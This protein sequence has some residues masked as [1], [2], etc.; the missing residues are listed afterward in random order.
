VA[1]V[2]PLS[3]WAFTINN[4]FTESL[5][6]Q[7]TAIPILRTRDNRAASWGARL[8]MM[9]SW[10]RFSGSAACSNLVSSALLLVNSI[11]P[12][13]AAAA[14]ACPRLCCHRRSNG[15][16]WFC[17]QRREVE[18]LRSVLDFEGRGEKH[19]ESMDLETCPG[20][21][22]VPRDRISR[23]C[24]GLRNSNNMGRILFEAKLFSPI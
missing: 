11:D 9:V 4:L 7:L 19:E 22:N 15:T 2:F 8:S 6:N 17:K 18:A 14:P 13:T 1:V 10:A 12:Y 24:D 3:M 21:L 5:R 16:F 20:N 23:R